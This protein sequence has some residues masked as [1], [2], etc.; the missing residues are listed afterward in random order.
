MLKLRIQQLAQETG[1]QTPE[2]EPITTATQFGKLCGIT[3]HDTYIPLW[4]GEGRDNAGK[5]TGKPIQK[6][7][8]I[9]LEKIIDGFGLSMDTPIGQLF[10]RVYEKKARRVKAAIVTGPIEGRNATITSKRAKV[11]T[12]KKKPA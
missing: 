7:S 5:P 4:T 6:M 9:T 11:S 8:M 2:G 3:S 10:E 1:A 12:K